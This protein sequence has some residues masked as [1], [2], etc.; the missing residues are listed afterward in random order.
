MPT[1]DNNS[2]DAA[3]FAKSI[4]KYIDY[5][6]MKKFINKAKVMNT[7]VDVRITMEEYVGYHLFLRQSMKQ[8]RELC[9]SKGALTHELIHETINGNIQKLTRKYLLKKQQS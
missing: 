8:L 6:K 9:K 3:D 1:D 4:V 2:I 7:L 5:D